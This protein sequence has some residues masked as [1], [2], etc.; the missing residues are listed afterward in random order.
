[1]K[2][3]LKPCPF[4]GGKSDV[5]KTVNHQISVD[6]KHYHHTIETVF[7]FIVMCEICCCQTALYDT[8]KEAIKAWNRRAK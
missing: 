5:Y 4:C 3:N 1:M 6:M 2:T 8:K 7:G